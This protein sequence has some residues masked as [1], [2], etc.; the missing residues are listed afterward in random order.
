HPIYRVAPPDILLIEAV[1]NIRP[2]SDVLRAGDEV[3]VKL[4]TPEPFAPVEED[5]S[6]IEAQFQYQIQAEFKLLNGPF[7]VQPD[8][9]LDLGPVYGRV[10]VAGLSLVA[11]EEAI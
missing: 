4:A 8:G 9:T 11:A 5:I 10:E 6:P 3:V 7:V 1:N 2:A